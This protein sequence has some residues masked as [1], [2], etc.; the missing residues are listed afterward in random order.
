MKSPKGK[1]GQRVDPYLNFRF[2][3]EID[4]IQQAGFMECMGLG[5]QVEVVE[6]REGRDPASVRKR[7]GKVS[8]PD[9]VLKWGVTDS[10][11]LYKWHLRVIQ[12]NL[13]RKAGA[14]MLLDS[15][16]NEKVRW[17]FFSAWPSKMDRAHA[18]RQGQRCG[19]RGAEAYLRAAGAS[20]LGAQAAPRSDLV[21]PCMA[22]RQ[23]SSKLSAGSNIS[24]TNDD[25]CS[26]ST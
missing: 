13:V 25:V 14:V 18:Q 1:K 11:E 8:Y 4:G 16:G 26:P 22:F 24:H 15:Q 7:A 6:Y 20:F 17:N 21:R 19:D 2:R 5:S 10:Q 9:I 12:G 3:V 23:L